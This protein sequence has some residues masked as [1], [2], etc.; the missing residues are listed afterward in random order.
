[1]PILQKVFGG[2]LMFTMLSNM[3]GLGDPDGRSA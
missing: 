1:M 2:V 3:A